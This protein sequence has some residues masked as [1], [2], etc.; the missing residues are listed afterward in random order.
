L[1]ADAEQQLAGAL[2]E[3]A[4]ADNEAGRASLTQM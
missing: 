4:L 2:L 1:D 3:D